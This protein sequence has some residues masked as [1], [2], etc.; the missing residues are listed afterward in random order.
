[1]I[2]QA[3]KSAQALRQ[4]SANLPTG[5]PMPPAGRWLTASSSANDGMVWGNSLSGFSYQPEKHCGF[6]SDKCRNLTADS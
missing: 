1:M 6:R 5:T 3:E 2:W 4:I